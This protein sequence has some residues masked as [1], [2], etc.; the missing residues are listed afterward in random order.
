M[1]GLL[2]VILVI[3]G[4]FALSGLLRAVLQGLRGRQ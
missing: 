1:S 2:V 4:V 3:I